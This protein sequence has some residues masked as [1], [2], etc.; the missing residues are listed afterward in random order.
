MPGRPQV[1][2]ETAADGPG[3]GGRKQEAAGWPGQLQPEL[4][5]Q[6]KVCSRQAG[7]CSTEGSKHGHR[8][9]FWVISPQPSD[10]CD[11]QSHKP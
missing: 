9:P 7:Q 6:P 8:P 5:T 4:D 10:E 11:P 1:D 2:R 3:T